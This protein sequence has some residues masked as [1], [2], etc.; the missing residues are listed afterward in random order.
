MLLRIAQNRCLLKK[1][2]NGE[3]MRIGLSNKYVFSWW[4]QRNICSWLVESI[5]I[6]VQKFLRVDGL[7]KLPK[8]WVRKK[9]DLSLGYFF[10]P[11]GLGFSVKVVLGCVLAYC[12]VTN[13]PV[14]ALWGW[15][16][17]CFPPPLEPP[18]DFAIFLSSLDVI[19]IVNC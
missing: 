2:R 15:T 14:I 12:C 17:V 6:W 8:T 7:L 4:K 10:F 13:L 3:I 18:L 1:L 16:W 19:K 11:L 9:I 5:P